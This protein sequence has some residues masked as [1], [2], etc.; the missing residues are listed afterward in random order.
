MKELFHHEEVSLQRPFYTLLIHGL[1]VFAIYDF[2]VCVP[3]DFLLRGFGV[4]FFFVFWIPHLFN[5]EA[6]VK[7]LHIFCQRSKLFG[8]YVKLAELLR[9]IFKEQKEQQHWKLP[10]S[11]QSALGCFLDLELDLVAG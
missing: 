4:N 2:F 6:L 7:F 5:V 8:S 3:S 9:N 11:E 10:F 1:M